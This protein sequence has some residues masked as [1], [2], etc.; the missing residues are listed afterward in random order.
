MADPAQIAPDAFLALRNLLEDN[1][2]QVTISSGDTVELES[3]GNYTWMGA[4]PDRH[5]YLLSDYNP[6][7]L[8]Y[9]D[10]HQRDLYPFGVV[11]NPSITA[12]KSGFHLYQD[13]IVFDV[14]LVGSRAETVNRF[15]S[16]VRSTIRS[17]QQ[18]LLDENFF[19]VDMDGTSF[20]NVGKSGG[21]KIHTYTVPVAMSFETTAYTDKGDGGG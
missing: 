12:N 20:P 17:E 9:S 10:E 3:Q 19:D 11:P 6:D 7:S 15:E 2:T 4:F 1:V 14:T 16:K 21:M 18:V 5:I 13:R 8:Q